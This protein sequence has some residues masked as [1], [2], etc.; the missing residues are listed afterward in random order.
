[1][2]NPSRRT[3]RAVRPGQATPPARWSGNTRDWPYIGVVTLNPQRD[4]EVSMARR[5]THSAQSR[6]TEATTTLTRTG[7]QPVKASAIE[8]VRLGAARRSLASSV[9]SGWPMARATTKKRAS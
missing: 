6:V 1:M 9:I 8:Q 5:S 4:T 7:R 3:P 2:T